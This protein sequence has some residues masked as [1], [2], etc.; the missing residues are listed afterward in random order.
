MGRFLDAKI[1]SRQANI[2]QK[3][4]HC[5]ERYSRTV[6]HFL[7]FVISTLWDTEAGLY[8]SIIHVVL[9]S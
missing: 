4:Y 3:K 6:S 9:L 5:V 1:D 7:K 8:F 2:D